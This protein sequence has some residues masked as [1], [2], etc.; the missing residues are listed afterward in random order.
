MTRIRLAIYRY[1]TEGLSLA[2]AASLAGVSWAQMKDMLTEQGV[3]L[4]LGPDGMEEA[5]EEV[6]ALRNHFGASCRR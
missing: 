5:L 1:Q 2:K 4:R 3:Q 6:D